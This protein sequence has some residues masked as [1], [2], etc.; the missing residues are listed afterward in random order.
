MGHFGDGTSWKLRYSF[1]F[2]FYSNYRYDYVNMTKDT[3]SHIDTIVS[4]Q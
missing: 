2:A 4:Y 3:F 1:L